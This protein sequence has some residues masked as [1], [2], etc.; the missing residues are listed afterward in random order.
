M[1]EILRGGISEALMGL[2]RSSI[3]EL[4][5]DDLIIPAGFTRSPANSRTT[6]AATPRTGG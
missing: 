3:H 2:G 6:A 1:L 5:N 4:T